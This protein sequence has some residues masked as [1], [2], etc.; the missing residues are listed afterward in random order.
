VTTLT[1]ASFIILQVFSMVILVGG[2]ANA[3]LIGTDS[4]SGSQSSTPCDFPVQSPPALGA[5]NIENCR[6]TQPMINLYFTNNGDSSGCTYDITINWADGK[7]TQIPSYPGGPQGLEFLASHK[8]TATGVYTITVT[9]SVASGDCYFDPGTGQFSYVS[10]TAPYPE[11]P[12]ISVATMLSRAADWISVP[13]QYS[14][15]DYYSDV[16]G[17]YRQDCSG[18]VSMA[19]DLDYSLSTPKLSTVATEVAS[20]LK[21]IE[22]GDIILRAGKHVF[23]FVKWANSAHTRATV[24][25]ETGVSSKTPYAVTKTLGVSSFNGFGVYRYNEFSSSN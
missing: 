5:S 19:W 12:P 11:G 3:S 13:V 9:G 16:N 23:L 25:E 6:S 7:T 15:T 20:G 1:K 10:S 8:Y 4:T 22:P 21:G 18:F 24:D 14:Q 2:T 17:T